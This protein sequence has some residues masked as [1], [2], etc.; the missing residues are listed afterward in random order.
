M[1]LNGGSTSI[2]Y[3]MLQSTLFTKAHTTLT[4]KKFGIP[5]GF[6]VLET[7]RNAAS[8][9]GMRVWS[10]N[11]ANCYSNCG[12]NILTYFL[13][14]RAVY[15]EGKVEAE[16]FTREFVTGLFSISKTYVFCFMAKKS[17]FIS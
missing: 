16:R 10:I 5:M 15:Y 7:N 12:E 13:P 9:L 8:P 2:N 4:S 17:Y 6:R 11:Y 14:L 3:T 1:F